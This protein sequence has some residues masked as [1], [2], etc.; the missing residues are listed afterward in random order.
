MNHAY[1]QNSEIL[2]L[3]KQ[4]NAPNVMSTPFLIFT[5][6]MHQK[7]MITTLHVVFCFLDESSFHVTSGNF[8]CLL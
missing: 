6:P 3:I 4:T 5:A 2:L 7:D 1:Q 8:K